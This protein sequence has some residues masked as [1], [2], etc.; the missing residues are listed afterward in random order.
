MQSGSG[1]V[2]VLVYMIR[3]DPDYDNPVLDRETIC[4][5]GSSVAGFN[6]AAAK[7]PGS[8]G[9]PSTCI[10]GEKPLPAV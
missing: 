2:L 10:R 8:G 3:P 9:N 6:R 1:L 5:D 4:Q 7:E